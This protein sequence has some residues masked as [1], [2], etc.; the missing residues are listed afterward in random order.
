MT[1][2]PEADIQ[3]ACAQLPQVLRDM[4]DLQLLT[5]AR[6]SEITLLK[7]REVNCTGEIWVADLSKRSKTMHHGKERFLYFGPKAQLILAKYLLRQADRYVFSPADAILQR[8]KNS[9]ISSAVGDCYDVHSYRRAIQRARVKAKVP[10]WAPN[11][12]RHNAATSIR[13][14]FGLEAAHVIL[15]HCK[16]ETSQIYADADRHKAMAV[17]QQRG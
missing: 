11:Q 14:E 4:V 16:V 10:Q 6:L 12:L 17:V 15:G 13:K 5:A 7:P 8:N 1:V 9:P 2:V 3:A